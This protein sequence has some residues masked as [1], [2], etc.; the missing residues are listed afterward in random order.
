[1]EN[2]K[3]DFLTKEIIVKII[4]KSLVVTRTLILLFFFSISSTLDNFYF[5][6]SIVGLVILINFLVEITYSQEINLHKNNLNFIKKFALILNKF[7][8]ILVL[9]LV[10]AAFS[11][12]DDREIIIHIF[13]LSTWGIFNINSNYYLLLY[14]FKEWNRK[15]LLYYLMIST[16]DIIL[17]LSML[18]VFSAENDF[19]AISLSVL[20]S[21]VIVFVLLFSNYGYLSYRKGDSK[22]VN[23]N[24]ETS[25]L[26]KIFIILS[27]ITV[28]DVSDN[29]FIS[30]LGEG[31]ITYYTYGLYAPMMIR[32]SLDIRTNFFVQ[33]NKTNNLS[34]TRIIF[35]NTLK[36]LMPFFSLGVIALASG[37]EVLED[38]IQK[39][40]N[41]DNIQ[42]FKNIIYIG[43][44]L[45]PLYIVWD[46]FYRFYYRESEIGKLMI[47]VLVG[48]LINITLN[49]GLG[50]YLSWGIYG[51]LISTLI[52]F[53]FYNLMSYQY[54]F[55]KMKE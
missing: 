5:S 38:T 45:M 21:E 7:S 31:Q 42:V 26:F 6:K 24:L 8:L 28:I 22:S 33:I 10:I 27:V 41:I 15:V 44:L 17:L 46:L 13:I 12:S 49:Y 14:R 20:T 2:I 52:V 16:F 18:N 11:I 34:E 3:L 29:Y 4:T 30:L 32:R 23:V 39:I 9:L 19:I 51:V 48:L 37:V 47:L 40:F 50:I 25:L 36:K 54:F 43:I 55:V 35:Y 53:L 1:M